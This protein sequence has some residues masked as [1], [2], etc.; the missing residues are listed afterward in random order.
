MSPTI[1]VLVTPD[2][3]HAGVTIDR[4][5]QVASR[6]A[7]DSEVWVTTVH[8]AREAAAM[9]FPGSPTIRVGGLDLEGS[10]VGPAAFACRRY[11][12]GEGVPAVWL[13]EA[14]LLRAN[15]R[16][17]LPAAEFDNIFEFHALDLIRAQIFC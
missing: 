2:C 14:G 13:I 5:R 8:D 3:P 10:N 17:A 7:P 16:V 12:G 11:E 6:L 4:V 15:C 1:E 9:G